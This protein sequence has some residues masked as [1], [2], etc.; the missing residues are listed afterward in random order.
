[1][2]HAWHGSDEARR[3]G[4]AL[5]PEHHVRP[6]C[7]EQSGCT[8]EK[9]KEREQSRSMTACVQTNVRRALDAVRTQVRPRTMSLFMEPRPARRRRFA[10]GPDRP[11]P[12]AP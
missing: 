1:M 7:A 9:V 6:L 8:V 2:R 4:S 11:T 10:L 5:T 3:P 12:T